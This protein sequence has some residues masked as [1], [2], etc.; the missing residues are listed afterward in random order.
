[1]EKTKNISPSQKGPMSFIW[2]GG[3]NFC[4]GELKPPE[5]SP[6]LATYLLITN[7]ESCEIKVKIAMT[8]DAIRRRKILQTK[9]RRTAYAYYCKGLDLVVAYVVYCMEKWSLIRE[10]SY[11]KIESFLNGVCR[12]MESISRREKMINMYIYILI[13]SLNNILQR[14]RESVNVNNNLS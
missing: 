11:K 13:I 1:M 3:L 5:A 14:R 6:C 4:F 8:K 10:R 12:R 2:F 9:I 7:D